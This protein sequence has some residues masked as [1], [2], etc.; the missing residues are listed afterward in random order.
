VGVSTHGRPDDEEI[1]GSRVAVY[2]SYCYE[3][4][5]GGATI[6]RILVWDWK[7]GELLRLCG[8]NGYISLSSPHQVLDILSTDRRELIEGDPQV[9]FLDEFR[10][11]V[12]PT[13]WALTELGVFN[14]LIRQDHPGN[15]RRFGFPTEFRN[16]RAKIF[17][18]HD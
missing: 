6:R 17:V 3:D 16:W 4:L 5:P 1:T 9:I 15:L 7:T 11:V 8:L 18:D 2:V 10:I 12:I 13:G 14:T